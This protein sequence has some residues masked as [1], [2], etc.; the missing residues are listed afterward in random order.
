VGWVTN[1]L[2]SKVIATYTNGGHAE[3]VFARDQGK[4]TNGTF[5]PGSKPSALLKPPIADS[6][7]VENGGFDAVLHGHMEEAPPNAPLGRTY[8]VSGLDTPAFSVP[9]HYK[10]AAENSAPGELAAMAMDLSFRCFLCAW[11]E[12]KSAVGAFVGV[13]GRNTF[14]ALVHFDWSISGKAKVSTTSTVMDGA[15]VTETKPIVFFT[16][17]DAKDKGCE[18]REPGSLDKRVVIVT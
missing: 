14:L 15:G 11:T 18:V 2:S 13:P 7:F 5:L 17:G 10:D 6:K 4:G 12:N 3:F 9:R 1:I 16:P 8:D